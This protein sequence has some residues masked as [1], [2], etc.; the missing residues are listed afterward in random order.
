[1]ARKVDRERHEARRQEVVAAAMQCFAEK[2]IHATS[3]AEICKAAGMSAGNL[4]YYFPSKDAIVQAIAEYDRRDMAVTFEEAKAQAD[5]IDGFM[6]ILDASLTQSGNPTFARLSLEI[7]TEATRNPA[8]AAMF[9][10]HE[11]MMIDAFCGLLERGVAQGTV[12]PDLDFEKAALWLI[13]IAEGAIGH[14]VLGRPFDPKAHHN[15]LVRLVKRF[16]AP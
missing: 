10:D 16:L 15:I 9:V 1:M 4:F 5:A 8:V 6:F 3:T 13:A 2:G 14:V 11:V 12:D 7:A